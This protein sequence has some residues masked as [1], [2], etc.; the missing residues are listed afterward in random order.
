[1]AMFTLLQ[2]PRREGVIYQPS[3]GLDLSIMDTEIKFKATAEQSAGGMSTIHYRAPVGFPGPPAHY[4][5]KMHEAFY[6]LEGTLAV[7]MNGQVSELAAGA[8]AFVPPYVV[9][10]FWNP[11]GSPVKFLAICTPGGME[12]YFRELHRLVGDEPVWPP[13]D[14]RKLVE[15]GERYDTFFTP[16]RAV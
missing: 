13:R 16:S 15:L 10:R 8:C 2:I 5:R 6:C 12:H 9:H 3:E 14:M 7:E 11:S 4:H 1:M